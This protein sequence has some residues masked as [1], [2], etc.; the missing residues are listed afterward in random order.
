MPFPDVLCALGEVM[1]S[2][3][4]AQFTSREW[5]VFLC[6]DNLDAAMS[7]RGSMSRQCGRRRLLPAPEAG[8]HP[9]PNLP[10]PRGRKTG[11]LRLHRHVLQPEPKAHEQSHAVAR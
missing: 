8:R 1:H 6:Q 10:D 2:D 4:G 7:R 5:Q 9:P 3:H 11:R